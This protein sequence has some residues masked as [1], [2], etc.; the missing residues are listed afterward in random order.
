MARAELV[1]RDCAGR[2]L[3]VGGTSLVSMLMLMLKSMSIVRKDREK[4][5]A[6]TG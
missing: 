2:R 4:F 5:A 1:K 3:R 6:P